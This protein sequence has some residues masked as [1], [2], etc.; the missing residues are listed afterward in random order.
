MSYTLRLGKEV[1]L[2]QV[3]E[4]KEAVE[5]LRA[6]LKA[7]GHSRKH[8]KRLRKYPHMRVYQMKVV[9]EGRESDPIPVR[10]RM[11]QMG[12]TTRVHVRMARIPAQ[13]KEA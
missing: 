8:E 7:F 3:I 2:I 6:A 4:G 9:Q 5:F 12:E 1:T 10:L 13:Q 11:E